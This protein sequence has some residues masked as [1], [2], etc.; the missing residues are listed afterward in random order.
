MAT[1]VIVFL[2]NGN[3]P[4][5]PTIGTTLLAVGASALI[6][7]I[8]RDLPEAQRF[9]SPILCF[10]GHTS[11]CVYLTHLTVLGLMHGGILGTRPDLATIPQLL[12]TLAALPIT[13]LV[14]WVLYRLVEVPSMNF[15]R[16]WTWSKER[17]GDKTEGGS[18][19][20]APA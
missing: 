5:F 7:C 16:R 1:A 3:G 9:K 19:S 4:L 14:G 2:E 12:V 13:V 10:F 17:R 6:L 18:L 15:G 11:Y 8:V 20:M